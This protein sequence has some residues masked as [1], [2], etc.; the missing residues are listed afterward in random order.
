M[1]VLVGSLA[2]IDLGGKMRWYCGGHQLNDLRATSLGV[3]LLAK[4]HNIRLVEPEMRA[5]AIRIDLT[6]LFSP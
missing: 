1:F 3:A 4:T 2:L 6:P 5:A